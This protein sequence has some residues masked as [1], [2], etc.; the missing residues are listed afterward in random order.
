MLI[1]NVQIWLIA[2]Y[3]DR[4][5]PPEVI[6]GGLWHD[7][8]RALNIDAGLHMSNDLIQAVVDSS[9]GQTPWISID[10]EMRIQVVDSIGELQSA[11]KSQNAAFVRRSRSLFIWSDNAHKV[12]EDAD[13]LLVRMMATVWERRN[14]KRP[15]RALKFV[16]ASRA[17]PEAVDPLE[18]SSKETIQK[19]QA[20]ILHTVQNS[21]ATFENA[22]HCED[23]VTNRPIMLFAPITT[24]LAIILA[25]AI[26]GDGIGKYDISLAAKSM[27][28]LYN[29][30][31]LCLYLGVLIKEYMLDGDATRFALLV[32]LPFRLCVSTCEY[33]N[34]EPEPTYL[35]VLSSQSSCCSSLDNCGIL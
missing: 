21:T 30:H 24:G 14:D 25:M 10:A 12:L 26:A 8:L 28:I 9:D 32:T 31:L 27:R 33:V 22:H 6:E 17:E 19:D 16:S 34:V 4:S 13:G 11:R 18:S 35:L 29:N 7:I 1:R 23:Q 20:E 15:R 2:K 5:F 3:L